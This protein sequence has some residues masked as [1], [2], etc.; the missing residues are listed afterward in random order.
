MVAEANV[1]AVAHLE[2]AHGGAALA[3]GAWLGAVLASGR[4]AVVFGLE[5][6]HHG[7]GTLARLRLAHAFWPLVPLALGIGALAALAAARVGRLRGGRAWLG[8]SLLALALATC[9]LLYWS[10]RWD[11]DPSRRIGLDT[12][13]GATA[14][15]CA[16]GA[17][18]VLAIVFAA[19][20]KLLER[21][22]AS[23]RAALLPL[24]LLLGAGLLL[25]LTQGDV[26]ERMLVRTVEHELY[27]EP[28]EVVERREDTGPS[29]Q[30]LS[31]STLY[32]EDGAGQPAL[33]LPPP[34]IVRRRMP[35]EGG[36]FYL[37]A[38]AGIDHSVAED[39]G[40]R[41]AGHSVRFV[42]RQD[43]AE[44]FRA[45]LPV[46]SSN[47]WVD[48]G[49]REGLR[50]PA[51][52]LLELETAMLGPGGEAVVPT[53]ALTIGFGGLELER[54][55]LIPRSRSSPETPN[56]VLVLIDTLRADH[57][58]AYGYERDT[59]PHL[60]E[61]A[62]R[63]VLFEEAFST[64][65]W[66]W[67]SIASILTGLQPQEHG[68]QDAASSFL[69]AR[70]DTLAEALQ[71]AGFT[72]AA[73]SGS[74]LIVADKNF[75]QGFEFF[76][77]SGEGTLRRSELVLPPALEWL[78]AVR[79]HRF[80]LYLHLMDSHAPIV[81]LPEARARFAPDVP[82]SF[83]PRKM[84]D[85]SWEL[86]RSGFSESG[87]RATD[88]V[89]SPEE[90]RWIADLYDAGVWSADDWLGR[91]L[92]RLDELELTEKTIV[93]VTSDHG[94]ELFDHGLL[95]HGHGLH[96]EL[97]RVPLVMAGPGIAR[98]GRVRTLLSSAALGPTLAR[99]GGSALSGVTE[100]LD[101][102]SEEGAP[103]AVLFSTRHGWWGGVGGQVLYGV[104]SGSTV[105]HYAPDGRAWGTM[106]PAK[107]DVRLYDLAADPAEQDDLSAR[108]PARTQ[109]LR[110]ELVQRLAE[111]E[112]RRVASGGFADEATLE[113]L[114]ALGY[115][116]R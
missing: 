71:R 31:P 19:R 87:E 24:G 86:Q 107:G 90:Q 48:V 22:L 76:D 54:R 92:A 63:G 40:E 12:A 72:T 103:D 36:V 2:T 11:P 5:L 114:R 38:G 35:D 79:D 28:W 26:A 106:S 32:W 43:G 61:L 59:T 93:V 27:S 97:V 85:Y 108:D 8:R 49:G 98:G 84:I 115:V 101:L 13:R 104:R 88:Q 74:P 10:G 60:R 41:Y 45:D 53:D 105:L 15:A 18:L 65:S 51:G 112:E 16:A 67:P 14:F 113:T 30:V 25:Q 69:S 57:T 100:P 68:V 1:A 4:A 7:D 94:E 23:W 21:L 78:G 58:S 102:F 73:W 96:R 91:V 62:Q 70:L 66:T 50:V 6:A 56:V 64:A 37:V 111:L 29:A 89:V 47:E 3:R 46:E 44:V 42:V 82:Q 20:V 39:V 83:D 109:A 80:F 9:S 33:L 81:P 55:V 75:D 110:D 17:A 34:A 116:G 99:L 77:S 95:T 52:A